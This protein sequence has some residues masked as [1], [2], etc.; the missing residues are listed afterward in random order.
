MGEAI[1]LLSIFFSIQVIAVNC[2]TCSIQRR[3][4][5]GHSESYRE[6]AS[7]EYGLSNR[8]KFENSNFQCDSEDVLHFCSSLDNL[9]ISC[10]NHEHNRVERSGKDSSQV[11]TVPI[12]VGLLL[13]RIQQYC[14]SRNFQWCTIHIRNF[15]KE[16]LKDDKFRYREPLIL[17]RKVGSYEYKLLIPDRFGNFNFAV[18]EKATIFCPDPE[19][20]ALKFSKFYTFV[21]TLLNTKDIKLLIYKTFLEIQNSNF[22]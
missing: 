13:Y 14:Y 19:K 8:D 20:N 9:Q 10:E 1:S 18:G 21:F 4:P 22:R 15:P 2:Q 16:T 6:P 12:L 7:Y 5:V 11:K 17:K 3:N